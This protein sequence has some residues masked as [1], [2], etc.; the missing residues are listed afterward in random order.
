MNLLKNDSDKLDRIATRETLL[1]QVK[2]LVEKYPNL[3]RE[4]KYEVCRVIQ[5][6]LN[7]SGRNSPLDT[8]E[9]V[10][11]WQTTLCLG[12]VTEHQYCKEHHLSAEVA[13]AWSR[14]ER[15]PLPGER[16]K[17]IQKMLWLAIQKLEW[18]IHRDQQGL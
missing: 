6:R 4:T 13:A 15:L 17:V 1:P 10:D 3:P 16:K 12:V 2:Q 11:Y 18:R 5:S 14:G 9:F 8:K 7:A